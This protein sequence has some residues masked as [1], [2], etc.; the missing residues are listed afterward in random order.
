MYSNFAKIEMGRS[1]EESI[2]SINL[3]THYFF[4]SQA[5]L[6]L[7]KYHPIL[8]ADILF[9]KTS[10]CKY[11]HFS[12]PP[13][14]LGETGGGSFGGICPHYIFKVYKL[15]SLTITYQ[16]SILAFEENLDDTFYFPWCLV[17]KIVV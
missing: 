11:M 17:E 16:N 13:F 1:G 5:L 6:S 7:I 10:F 15:T 14:D 9:L 8:Y 2:L 3:F 4:S 12:L